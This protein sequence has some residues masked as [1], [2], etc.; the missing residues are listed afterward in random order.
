MVITWNSEKPLALA[1]NE[2]VKPNAHLLIYYSL[3]ASR[4]LEKLSRHPQCK[5]Q[6]RQLQTYSADGEWQ[7]RIRAQHIVDSELIQY[8]LRELKT[9]VLLEFGLL[10]ADAIQNTKVGDVNLSQTSS[11]FRAFFDMYGVHYDTLPVRRIQTTNMNDLSFQD[12]LK[13]LESVE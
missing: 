8:E 10:V 6:L 13:Q 11:A 5:V 3:G 2:A 1:A 9:E 7:N 4:S 12:V